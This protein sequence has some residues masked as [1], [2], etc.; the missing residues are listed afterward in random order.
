M[1]TTRIRIR[2]HVYIKKDIEIESQGDEA[3]EIKQYNQ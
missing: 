2:I 3:E 1:N